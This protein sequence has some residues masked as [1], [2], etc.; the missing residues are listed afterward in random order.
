MYPVRGIEKWLEVP[1]CK[2]SVIAFLGNFR[3]NEPETF[4]L[5]KFQAFIGEIISP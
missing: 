2:D 5:Q 3:F 1:L 4:A